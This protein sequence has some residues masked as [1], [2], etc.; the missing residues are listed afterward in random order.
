M[1]DDPK[2]LV[3]A[4]RTQMAA[5]ESDLRACSEGARAHDALRAEWS[6]ERQAKPTSATYESWREGRVTQAAAGSLL[7][8]VF[9][10]F[11]EDN[12]LIPGFYLGE[13]GDSGVGW[14]HRGAEELR[15]AQFV[16]GSDGDPVNL[17]ELSDDAAQSLA[18]FWRA[19]T[20]D[21]SPAFDFTDP[22]LD[23]GFLA[24]IYQDLSAGQ[25]ATYAL[26][27]TPGFVA[28]FILNRTLKPAIKRFGLEDLRVIDPVCGSGT[29]LLSAF[30]MI[31]AD[32]E[33]TRGKPR[34]ELA[35]RAL[36]A[37]HGVDK[38]PVAV[39][40]TRFRL[41]VEV[42]KALRGSWFSGEMPDLN[43]QVMIGDSLL[44]DPPEENYHV[45][46]GNPP[47]IVPKDKA[48]SA[49]Y[50][51]KYPDCVGS[52][53]LTVP[54]ME[55]FFEL[56]IR[57]SAPEESGYVGI[58]VSNS[59]MKREFGRSIV[60]RFFPTVDLTDVIDT[61]G[62]Y[63]PGHGTPT[64]ILLGR[65]SEPQ[66][67]RVKAVVGL[68]GEPHVPVDPAKGVVWQSVLRG[69]VDIQYHDDWVQVQ[70]V[71]RDELK[72]FPWTLGDKSA[73]E[74]I[75]RMEH[76]ARLG[77]R[78]ARIG[79]FANTGADEIFMAPASS[80]QRARVE[81]E[82]LV[83]A[84]TGSEVR[85]WQVSPGA[86]AV[87]FESADKRSLPDEF[88]MHFRR[89]WPYRTTLERRR[90]YS[91]R[92]YREDN[93]LWYGWHHITEMPSASASWIVFSW[94]STHNHFAVLRERAAPLQSAPVVRLPQTA[95]DADVV[96]LAALLNSSLACFWLKHYSN[97]KGQPGVGQTGTGEPW[98]V[99]YEF[100]GT[101]LA[102]FP[103]P[104]D[105]WSGDRWSLHAEHLDRLVRALHDTAPMS[106][107]S[108]EPTAPVSQLDDA[109]VRWLKTRGNLVASQEE[110]DWEIY[111][112]YGLPDGADEF[113][114]PAEDV[115][116]LTPGERAFEISLARRKADTTWFVRNGIEPVTE[117][118]SRWPA[119][120]REVVEKRIEALERDPYLRLIERPEFK[121]RW[122]S[123][124]WEEQEKTAIRNWLLDRCEDRRL[125]FDPDGEH[126]RPL[127]LRELAQQLS[128]EDA[129]VEMVK[130]YAGDEAEII[131]V[132]ADLTQTEQVPYLA[133]LR[134]SEPGLRKYHAWSATWRLQREAAENGD[135]SD[136]P[137]PP[138]YSRADFLKHDYWRLRGKLD[139]ANERF[140]SYPFAMPDEEQLLGWA[141]WNHAERASVLVDL[142]QTR[143]HAGNGNGESLRPL[144]AGLRELLFW[145]ELWHSSPEPPLWDGRP[146]DESRGFLERAQ[147]ALSL[148]DDDLSSWRP[149]KPRRGR[150]RKKRAS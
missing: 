22:E 59:F 82:P 139:V 43:V 72:T 64:A 49:L 5:L 31:L 96:Q 124:G 87:M 19:R 36:A 142:A 128:S 68:R 92:S 18:D 75:R 17:L 44:D 4:L 52:Y 54:F 99:F 115:P 135:P 2:V 56:G 81:P 107:L 20:A 100:T 137:A 93:R 83:P 130:R 51:E 14:M 13:V 1:I 85:D 144:L 97:S 10:R 46:V 103:L 84:I 121:R 67:S 145:L 127:T 27:E 120:Y 143:M 122:V 116:G 9:L 24:S 104:P 6:S 129:F 63:I 39:A 61:S 126:P 70:D 38:N 37:V 141:G 89:L 80:F 138:K 117:I 71:E 86:E 62:V 32:P 53:A 26:L 69:T 23:T 41:M 57:G 101:R 78:G 113:L 146:A 48:E 74:I 112:R 109:R 12:D 133:A 110:L 3:A 149:P 125:W 42:H 40:V 8:T 47:Y 16:S 34:P 35:S 140:I 21:G 65:S 45:V 108:G 88:P 150:P 111:A 105:R 119:S 7:R 90:N 55:R 30:R 28:D 77:G 25:R 118:P 132:V 29:F 15:I 50:R 58:I 147:E 114:A 66:R 95:S 73:T 136:I 76:G 148:S 79:Y 60:E 98:T 134:Y 131:D 33:G 123:P 11:A 106:V 94:V 102:E 91:G